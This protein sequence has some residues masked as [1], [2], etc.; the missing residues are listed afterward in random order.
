MTTVNGYWNTTPPGWATH[1][2]RGRIA[3]EDWG[4]SSQALVD[5][6][7]FMCGVYF[8]LWSGQ[9]LRALHFHPCQIELLQ[10]R[11]KRTCLIY[12][13]DI[14]KNNPGGL[15]GRNNK[16]I[17]VT[18]FENLDNPNWCFVNL[19]KLYNSKCPS[20]RPKDAF[21][22]KPLKHPTDTCWYSSQPIGHCTLAGT[23]ARLC[24]AAGIQGYKTNHSLRATTA[25]RLYQA[26]IDAA[27]KFSQWKHTA[28][29]LL[30]KYQ[31]VMWHIWRKNGGS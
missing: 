21:Y 5:T 18:H 23:V 16:P 10:Q 2:W 3:V 22:L 13:E 14:S 17:T 24:K 27:V 15:R 9:E 20:D 8:A 26:S 4:H 6:I 28:H 25:T 1:C 30:L 19:S 11:G 31:H 29:V 12:T 7:L